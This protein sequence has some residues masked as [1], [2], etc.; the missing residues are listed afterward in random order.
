MI[1]TPE[2]MIQYNIDLI[3]HAFRDESDI[4]KQNIY[5]RIVLIKC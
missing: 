1:I 5:Y 2:F 3:A 4:N